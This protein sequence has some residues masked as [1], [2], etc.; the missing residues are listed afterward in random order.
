[1]HKRAGDRI[2]KAAA[3]HKFGG[4]NVAQPSFFPTSINVYVS[5]RLLQPDVWP[6]PPEFSGKKRELCLRYLLFATSANEPHSPRKCAGRVIF[7]NGQ[8]LFEAEPRSHR[9]G[10][11]ANGAHL[12]FI[13]QPSSCWRRGS[14]LDPSTSAVIVSKRLGPDAYRSIS[15][16]QRNWAHVPEAL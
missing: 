6:F 13:S 12:P 1:M 7:H 8:Q 4:Q 11:Q 16:L 9:L 10:P 2:G 14:A 15:G 5:S 3:T